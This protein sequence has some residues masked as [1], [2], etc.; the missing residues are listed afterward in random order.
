MVSTDLELIVS[1]LENLSQDALVAVATAYDI[2]ATYLWKATR[3]IN[4]PVGLEDKPEDCNSFDL[5]GPHW[6]REISGA[7]DSLDGDQRRNSS[8]P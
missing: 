8:Y 2:E 1:F 5:F 6:R 7:F 3:R 4:L